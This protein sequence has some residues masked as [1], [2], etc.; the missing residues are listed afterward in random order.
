VRAALTESF[1]APVA[2]M[3]GTS[4]AGPM[5]IGCWRGPG[6]HLCDDLVIIEPVDLAGR[7]GSAPTRST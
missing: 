4:E 1:C 2:N 3:Y 5:G 6:L 7:P